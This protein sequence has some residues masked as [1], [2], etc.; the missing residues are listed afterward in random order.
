LMNG[1]IDRDFGLATPVI[2]HDNNDSG[3]IYLHGSLIIP[4]AY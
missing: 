2:P 3:Q 1:E 4:L